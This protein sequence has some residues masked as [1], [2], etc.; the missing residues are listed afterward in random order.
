MS[1]SA[2]I[3]CLMKSERTAKKIIMRTISGR[4]YKFLRFWWSKSEARTKQREIYIYSAPCLPLKVLKMRCM[5]FCMIHSIVTPVLWTCL[6]TAFKRL[7]TACCPKSGYRWN[8]VLLLLP[9][10]AW[11]GEPP[12]HFYC[13][14]NCR[15]LRIKCDKCGMGWNTPPLWVNIS[16]HHIHRNQPIWSVASTVFCNTKYRIRL[17]G[18]PLN[19]WRISSFSVSCFTTPLNMIWQ[20]ATSW[21]G[22]HLNQW[23][24]YEEPQTNSER[25]TKNL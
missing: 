20:N 11:V 23:Q 15:N 13:C 10:L 1:I 14:R 16:L 22:Y 5:P 6:K 18:Q 21:N 19:P 9:E 8:T 17:Q 2:I 3:L 12:M 25:S 7:F 4:Q 24:S